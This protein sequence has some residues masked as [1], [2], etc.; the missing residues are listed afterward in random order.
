MQW[1]VLDYYENIQQDIEHYLKYLQS[2]EYIYDTAYLPHDAKHDRIGMKNTIEQ[3]VRQLG[4]R[5]KIVPKIN[6]KA[7]AINAARMIFPSCYFDERNCAE[8]LERLRHYT[9]EVVHG[10]YQDGNSK[11]R[12]SEEP[13]HDENSNAADAFMTFAQSVGLPK[14]GKSMGSKLARPISE[15][16]TKAPGQGWMA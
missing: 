14:K 4:F 13:L 8:G 15:L 3:Q 5:K 11:I 7:L 2:K 16:A 6:R 12:L 10:Q 1:R 9:Y